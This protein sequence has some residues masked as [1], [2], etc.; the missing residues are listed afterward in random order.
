MPVIGRIAIL[1]VIAFCTYRAD[2][3]PKPKK[4]KVAWQT[5]SE[6]TAQLKKENKPLLIDVYTTW[7]HYCK[8]MDATT[9]SND[10][11]ATYLEKNFYRYKFNAETR[12][13]IQWQDKQFLY[14]P[15]Y[16]V[17][18]FAV[19]LSKGSIVYPTTVIITPGGQPYFQFGALKPAELEVLLKYYGSDLYKGQTLEEF[20][21]SYTPLW[22]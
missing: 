4:K 8:L 17:H 3:T 13:T 19:Y 7:C 6:V 11:V 22:K 9:Y 20:S 10:S 1:I 18:D 12:D 14:N 15:R 16:E 5:W 2:A 21:K